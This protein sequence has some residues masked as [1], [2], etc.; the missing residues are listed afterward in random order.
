[1]TRVCVF[2]GSSVGADP[3]YAA[4]ARRLAAA[5]VER[6]LGVVYGG[7]AVGL[8]G[9]LADAL[10]ER[11]GEVIGVIPRGLVARE[12]AHTRLTEQR[13]VDSMHERKALMA[14]L[15]DAFVVLPG[16]VGTLE[17]MFEVLSWAQ[18]GIHAKPIGVLDVRGFWAGLQAHLAHAVR[19][20]FVRADHAALLLAADAP[21]PLLDAM[22]TWRPPAS[23]RPWLAPSQI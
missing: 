19:E 18:L 2:C 4:A 13:I 22:A 17:E 14:S 6:G 1:M 8:M 12:V 11:G 23:V 3:A 9:V 20:G 16:G 21:E 15:A 7:G 5:L 10:L